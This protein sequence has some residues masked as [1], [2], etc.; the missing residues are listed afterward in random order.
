MNWMR[1]LDYKFDSFVGVD[2]VPDLV[3]ALL[4]QSWPDGFHFQVGNITTDILSYADAVLCRDCLVHLP[5]RKVEQATRL[6]KRARFH[7]L[8]A[9]TFPA[10][11][12]NQDC[13]IGDWRPLNMSLEPFC[14]GEPLLLLP[15]REVGD[16]FDYPDKS[17]GIWV[18]DTLVPR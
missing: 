17:L 18:P 11:G 8:I 1:R 13:G 4:L 10:Q 6:F 2:I 7:Y 12:V 14:W 5:F 9:T 15:E 3:H 16:G